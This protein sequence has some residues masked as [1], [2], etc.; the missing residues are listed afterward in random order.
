MVQAGDE[1]PAREVAAK[2]GIPVIDLTPRSDGPAGAFDLSSP[3]IA[4]D[5]LPGA[6]APDDIALV[7]HTSG[8]TSR[9]KIVPLSHRNVCA[10]ARNIGEVLA[11]APDDRCLNVMPLFHIHGLIAAVLSS[12]A[13]GGSVWCSP[14]FNALR[15]FRLAGSSEAHLVHR[16]S[17][18]AP[19]DRGARG[20]KPRHHRDG[21]A[22]ADPVVLILFAPA[23]DGGS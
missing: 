14:G 6:A 2:L 1:T 21:W 20:P 10:S 11:L 23:G 17:H 22:A 15:F 4:G 16:G 19:G 7:L 3:E 13:A 18:D 12:L 9:P 8:T 5:C